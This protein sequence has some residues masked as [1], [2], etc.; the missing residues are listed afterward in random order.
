MYLHCNLLFSDPVNNSNQLAAA[1][2]NT[3][4]SPICMQKVRLRA[5]LLTLLRKANSV[6]A[7][8][9]APVKEGEFKS[10]LLFSCLHFSVLM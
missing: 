4:Y 2:V 1:C 5:D 3:C 8:R 9:A 7:A 6:S 10:E